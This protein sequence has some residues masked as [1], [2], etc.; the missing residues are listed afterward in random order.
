M[1]TEAPPN[2][3]SSAHLAALLDA[4]FRALPARLSVWNTSNFQSYASAQLEGEIV[5][6]AS[7][8]TRFCAAVYYQTLATGDCAISG[9][10]MTMYDDFHLDLY[11]PARVRSLSGPEHLWLHAVV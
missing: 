11:V 9:T 6:D 7:G 8:G 5:T 2:E 10:V 4:T 1:L 3:P